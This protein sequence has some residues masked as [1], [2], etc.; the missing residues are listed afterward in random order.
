MMENC[1]VVLFDFGGTLDAEGITWKDR[2]FRHC[3]EE[4]IEVSRE[5][6]DPAF[7]AANDALVGRLPATLGLRETVERL[8][9][10]LAGTLGLADGS[11]A[12]RLAARFHGEARQRLA[13]S[14]RLLARL[15]RRY[16][17]GIVS[18]FYGNLAAVCA[19]AGIAPSLSVAIDSAVVGCT[20][21]DR[22]IFEAA[23]T[24]LRAHA[25]EAVFV[26]DSA[27]RDM[28]GA[29]EAGMR[30]VWLAAR[31]ANGSARPCCPGD[32][33]I[34]RLAEIEEILS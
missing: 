19:E 9:G 26:G 3:R 6:F 20:K 13:E 15:S 34:R 23:L 12:G 11:V 8:A 31:E 22:R 16:R 10:G 28:A 18:N 2:F 24:P 27:P 29:R 21:P 4:G 7:Y 25:G 17:L 33:V 30:H 1:S 32:P 5:R 14:A